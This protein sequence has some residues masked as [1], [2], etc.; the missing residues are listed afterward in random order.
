M[1]TEKTEKR[2]NILISL[3]FNIVV[4]VLILTKLAKYVA[5]EPHYVLLIALAFPLGYAV[6]DFFERKK[7]NAISVLGFV[8]I[9]LTG[10]IGL[11]EF[12]AD[13]IAIKEAAVPLV[14]GIAV[15]VS[16]QT[17]YPLVKTFIYNDKI[18]DI[19][20]IDAI[21]EANG[22]RKEMEKTLNLSSIYL[23]GSF[24]ISSI[25][26][27]VLAKI[28]IQSPTGT[29]EF[30]AELGRMTALSYP[31]IALPCTIIMVFI[32][33]Y[34]IRSLTRLSELPFEELLAPQMR[35]KAK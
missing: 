33:W 21:L 28:L 19:N 6:Y 29:A 7:I 35:D 22:K 23:A 26:N 30:N 5:L 31:V 32:L 9:L 13:W 24:F 2:E 16:T 10:V 4:P 8:S 3:S 11:F 34:L 14:I 17:K 27:F 1:T 12:P 20:R 18:L 25:L 15:L